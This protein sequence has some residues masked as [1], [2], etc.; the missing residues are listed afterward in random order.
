LDRVKRTGASIGE[1]LQFCYNRMVIIGFVYR[2][3]GRSPL[4]SEITKILK[5]KYYNS[6]TESKAFIGIVI[7]YYIWIEGFAVITEPIYYLIR[8]GIIWN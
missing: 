8:K 7:Y 5:W 6:I 4:S 1:K 3:F 2:V